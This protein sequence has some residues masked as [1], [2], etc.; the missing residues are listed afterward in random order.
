[1]VES[2]VEVERIRAVSEPAPAPAVSAFARDT[3]VRPSGDG[4]YEGSL[5][6]RWWIGRAPN[7]GYLAALIVRAM[8]AA[9][10]DPSR[11]ARTI[12]V[13]YLAPPEPGPV[14]IEVST[15][16][17]GR[18]LSTLS[19][20]VHQGERSI[21]LSLAA[22]SEPWPS[23]VEHDTAAPPDVPRPEEIPLPP[24]R[25]PTFA[26]NWELRFALGD[27]PFS[28][29]GEAVTGGWIRLVEPVLADAAYVMQ[30]A[31]AWPPAVF[32]LTDS[33]FPAPTVEL[34]V[35]FRSTLPVEGAAADDFHLLRFRTEI[36]REGVF[37]EAGEIWAPDGRLL[38]QSRQ[39]AIAF[40][41][42]GGGPPRD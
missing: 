31:D 2:C 32:Q 14:T 9:V 8:E 33:F 24:W 35:H 1:L 27:T 19:A 41:G 37:E 6:R 23:E 34:T 18:A 10:A 13:H 16:R 17:A 42:T 12:T 30:L 38:A 39:L 4:V 29:A 15:E 7:G 5:D 36:V 25:G 26:D 40:P 22:F 20:R 28:G 21:A 11:A 3:A